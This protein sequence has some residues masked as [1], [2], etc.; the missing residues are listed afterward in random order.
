MSQ[1]S[2]VVGPGL[3]AARGT[4]IWLHTCPMTEGRQHSPRLRDI[5]RAQLA[6]AISIAVAVAVVVLGLLSW[7]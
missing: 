3:R 1:L 5:R 4:R 2:G 6:I 7:R